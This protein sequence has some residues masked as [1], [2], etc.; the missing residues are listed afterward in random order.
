MADYNTTH[1]SVKELREGSYIV[2]D[3]E[4]CKIVEMEFSSPGKHGSAKAR[5][6]GIGIFDGQKRTLLEPADADVEVPEILKKRAQ[7]V[8][9]TQTGVQLMDLDTYE[10]FETTVGN[11][12]ELKNNIKPGQEVEVLESM[13]RRIITRILGGAK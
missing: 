9:V 4:P 7:V 3:N 1:K 12:E 11:D 13:G 6:T 5:I 10:I 2:I 8:A